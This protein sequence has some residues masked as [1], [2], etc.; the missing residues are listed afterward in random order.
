MIYNFYVNIQFQFPWMYMPRK[1]LAGSDGN[2]VFNILRN[3][4]FLFLP[5]THESSS[6]TTS[7]RHWLLLVFSIIAVLMGRKCYPIVIW[8]RIFLTANIEYLF[9]WLLAIYESSFKKCVLKVFILNWVVF[10][11]FQCPVL[12][13]SYIWWTCI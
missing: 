8:I 7:S 9:M 5:P 3:C 10:F 12:R 11:F 4:H 6:F 13:I 2:S 1:R